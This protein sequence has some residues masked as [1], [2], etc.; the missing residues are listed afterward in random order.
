MGQR[1][2]ALLPFL[3]LLGCGPKPA[4]EVPRPGV[5]ELPARVVWDFEH[6]V[7]E[8]KDAMLSLF[9]FAAVGEVEILLHRYDALG[10]KPGIEDEE[11]EKY[12]A[13]D[14]TPYPE[15]RERRNIGNFYE[16]MIRPAIGNGHCQALVPHW[17]Y[18]Q[19]LGVPFDPLPP[20]NETH[21]ALRVKVNAYLENG[22]GGVIAIRCP[23]GTRGLA[24]MYTRRDNDR[25][26]DIITIYDDGPRPK[27]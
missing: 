15:K 20:G 14:G 24:L 3:A 22:Q 25:G 4:A 16:W 17:H 10:R 26:Y 2:V 8:S 19:L 18:N 9:D 12:L 1:G 21:E 11:I 6:G 27:L 23:G 13:E 5:D 7:R